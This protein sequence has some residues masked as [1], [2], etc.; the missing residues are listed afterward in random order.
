MNGMNTPKTW[1]LFLTLAFVWWLTASF[2]SG[3][4]KVGSPAV[5]GMNKE[6]CESLWKIDTAKVKGDTIYVKVEQMPEFP[7]NGMKGLNDFIKKHYSP[8][9][10]SGCFV[11]RVIVRFV[12]EKDGT[13]TNAKVIRTLDPYLD[14]KALDV[15]KMM[16]KW[17]PGMKD[18]K[19]VRVYFTI[20]L[21]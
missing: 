6:R 3:T 5:S 9:V 19:P 4:E 21:Y 12:V 16:P 20:P 1:T 15:M 17:K 7:Y 2:E 18:G 10:D 8:F 14:K 13:I 11:G